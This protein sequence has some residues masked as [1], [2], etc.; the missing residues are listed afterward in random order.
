M[1]AA[2]GGRR[3]SR[4]PVST[5][6][7]NELNT[8]IVANSSS[9]LQQIEKWQSQGTSY[10]IPE[11]VGVSEKRAHRALLESSA[12][13][14]TRYVLPK[15]FHGSSEAICS[16]TTRME[17]YENVI[18]MRGTR[19][20]PKTSANRILDGVQGQCLRELSFRR[21]LS[22]AIAPSALLRDLSWLHTTDCS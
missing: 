10:E 3:R 19:T 1:A 18:H 13:N 15:M 14:K 8:Y 12:L 7:N 16:F 21:G 6:W 9:E 17:E 22:A 5:Q 2:P 4:E 20:L 11:V